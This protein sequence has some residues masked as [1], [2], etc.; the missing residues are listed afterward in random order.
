MQ[1]VND[2]FEFLKTRLPGFPGYEH[3]DSRSSS[4]KQVRAFVGEALARLRE[5]S[6]NTLS[7]VD[8]ERLDSLLLRCEF[9]DQRYIGTLQ[10]ADFDAADLARLA[11]QDRA[12][13]ESV[14][15]IFEG[16][17]THLPAVIDRMNELFDARRPSI[18]AYLL[19]GPTVEDFSVERDGDT[20]RDV[21]F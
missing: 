5:R 8:A 21:E 15:P 9:A 12:I 10:H 17:A 13:V 7:P 6:S 11:K 16:D 2:D 19:A 4:D 14:A 3:E 20:G 1:S 18:K